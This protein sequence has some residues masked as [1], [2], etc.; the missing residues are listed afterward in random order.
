ARRRIL[1]LDVSRSRAGSRRF[2][3]VGARRRSRE[4]AHRSASRS[5]L[6]RIFDVTVRRVLRAAYAVH[7]RAGTARDAADDD[8]ASPVSAGGGD[9]AAAAG[10][11]LSPRARAAVE[12]RP[13]PLLR[14]R[15]DA[16]ERDAAV[17]RRLVRA[18]AKRGRRSALDG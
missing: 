3:A 1:R 9:I 13:T 8:T 10:M 15:A 4:A 12:H 18:G 11:V 7:P 6:R 16:D 5:T 17:R 14:S 2:V